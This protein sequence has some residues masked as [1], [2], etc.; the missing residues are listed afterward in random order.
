MCWS[1]ERRQLREQL[2]EDWEGSPAGPAGVG[3]MCHWEAWTG[4]AR[5]HSTILRRGEP[6]LMF[7]KEAAFPGLQK[8]IDQIL[9]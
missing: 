4:E 8:G 3:V 2:G 7:N 1:T 9:P 5:S 6:E